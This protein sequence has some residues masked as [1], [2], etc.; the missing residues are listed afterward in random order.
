MLSIIDDKIY[1][2]R[3]DDEEIE[4]AV[5]NG[6]GTPYVVQPGDVFTLTVREN[7]SGESPVLLQTS[8]LPGSSRIIIRHAD[9]SELN[10][11]AYSADIQ[12]LMADGKRKTIWPALKASASR[13]SSSNLRNFNIASEVTM[14]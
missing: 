4:V 7:P 10:Y 3:G 13:L 9:T 12:L 11:G 8:S 1:M 14:L 5:Q 2:V 6:D